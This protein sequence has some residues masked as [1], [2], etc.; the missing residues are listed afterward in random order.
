MTG[1]PLPLDTVVENPTR[2]TSRTE[3]RPL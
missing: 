3:R 2:T 1:S